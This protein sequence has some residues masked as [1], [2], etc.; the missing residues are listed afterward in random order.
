MSCLLFV[1]CC[2]STPRQVEIQLRVLLIFFFDFFA[3]LPKEMTTKLKNNKERKRR[4]RRTTQSDTTK[5]E[6]ATLEVVVLRCLSSSIPALRSLCSALVAQHVVHEDDPPTGLSRYLP[7]IVEFFHIDQ[8]DGQDETT[9]SSGGQVG[10][11]EHKS[12]ERDAEVELKQRKKRKGK[13]HD[14]S[15]GA[16]KRAKTSWEWE[17]EMVEQCLRLNLFTDLHELFRLERRA[18]LLAERESEVTLLRMLSKLCSSGGEAGMEVA[19]VYAHHQRTR[20]R[21]FASSR[22]MLEWFLRE[23]CMCGHTELFRL[24]LQAMSEAGSLRLAEHEVSEAHVMGL[25]PMLQA[26]THKRCT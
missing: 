12:T 3:F 16:A 11:T 24:V 8:D 10:A 15:K 22:A 9:Q 2:V 20:G 26:N 18:R 1:L 6:S 4:R 23:C 14:K 7:K 25:T 19:R 21:P 17:Q 5:M 13:E